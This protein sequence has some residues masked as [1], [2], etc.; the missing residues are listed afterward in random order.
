M[1]DNLGM[2]L[3]LYIYIYIYIYILLER[4]K[5]KL[6]TTLSFLLS[7]RASCL[8]KQRMFASKREKFGVVDVMLWLV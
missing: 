6:L 4:K 2:K 1:R 7:N 3:I 8:S 5:K